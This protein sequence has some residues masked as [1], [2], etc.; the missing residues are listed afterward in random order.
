ML[1]SFEKQTE[2]SSFNW[3]TFLGYIYIKKSS[4][5]GKELNSDLFIIDHNRP[6]W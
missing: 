6:E 2:W 5:S 1:Q 3:L 4:A